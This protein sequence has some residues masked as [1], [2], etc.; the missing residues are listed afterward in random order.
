[1]I[2][3]AILAKAL[4]PEAAAQIDRILLRGELRKLALVAAFLLLA[5]VGTSF[6]V[7]PK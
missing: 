4:Y 5:A 7:P 3:G 6:G 1:M 2:D